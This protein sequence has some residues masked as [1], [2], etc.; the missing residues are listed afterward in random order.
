MAKIDYYDIKNYIAKKLQDK[1]SSIS[2]SS[3]LFENLRRSYADSEVYN[4][5]TV[6]YAGKDKLS[7]YQIGLMQQMAEDLDLEYKFFQGYHQLYKM[8]NLEDLGQLLR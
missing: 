8:I 3:R 4:P 2:E 1:E 6:I 5:E 7:P